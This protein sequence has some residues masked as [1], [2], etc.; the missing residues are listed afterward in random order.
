M[1]AIFVILVNLQHGELTQSQFHGIKS[2]LL[3]DLGGIL[4]VFGGVLILSRIKYLKVP[5]LISII[6]KYSYHIFLDYVRPVLN[7]IHYTL[8]WVEHFYHVGNNCCCD[9]HFY[10][11]N[12]FCQ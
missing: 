6:D 12:E 7:G 10:Y 9:L 5:H 8:Y 4:S 2:R 1:L 3:H 11:G